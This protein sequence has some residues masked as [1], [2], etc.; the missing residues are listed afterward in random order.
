MS[1]LHARVHLRALRALRSRVRGLLYVFTC[2]AY[3]RVWC[4]S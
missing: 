1:C 4:A 2:L 3:L